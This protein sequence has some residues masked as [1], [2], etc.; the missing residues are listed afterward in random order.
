[1]RQWSI[2]V[3]SL[4][5]TFSTAGMRRQAIF[6]LL[7]LFAFAWGSDD[8]HV[9]D[10]FRPPAVPLIVFDPYMNI[11]ST[12]NNLY[13]SWPSLWDGAT[14]GLS[15]LIRV[16]GK[17]YRFMGLGDVANTVSQ[18]SVKVLPTTTVYKFK[19]GGVA[20]TVRFITP[21]IPQDIQLLSQPVSYI[22]YD[23][24]SADGKT[25]KV[26]LYYD[27]S[28][29]VCSNWSDRKITW[30]RGTVGNVTFLKMGV[31]QQKEFD[32]IGDRVGINWGYAYVAVGD[33]NAKTSINSD[34]TSRKTFA[35]TGS[36]PTTDDTRK[37]RAVQDEWPVMSVSWS[38]TLSPQESVSK[39]VIFAYDDVHSINW[40]GTPFPPLWKQY[41]PSTTGLLETA[42]NQYT[43]IL[44]TT[45]RLDAAV[46][47]QVFKAAGLHYSTIASLA[48]RQTF[49]AHK[50]VYNTKLKVP[51]YFLKEIS[52]NGDFSTV[53]VLFP[54]IPLLLWANPNLAEMILLPHL[55]YAAG[56]APIKYDLPW[57]PHQLGV[58]PVADATPDSQEQMPV[59]ET[60]NLLLIAEYLA[61]SGVQYTKRMYPRYKS[62]FDKWAKYLTPHKLTGVV[63]ENV[64]RMG[65]DLPNMPTTATSANDCRQKCQNKDG[66][67]SW[68]F[69][70]CSKNR[71]WLK[72]TEGQA[73]PADCRSSGLKKP[74]SS[75]LGGI[76]PDPDNQLCTDDFLGPMPHNVNLAAKGILAVD[77]YAGFLKNLGRANESQYFTSTAK[78][79]SDWWMKNGK[80]GDHYRIQFDTPNSF[81]LQYNLIFQKF[82]HLST[83][84]E[85]VL[86]N[87]VNYYLNHQWNKYGAPLNSRAAKDGNVFTKLDWLS[88]SACLTN[89][90]K[91]SDKFWR[92][93]FQLANDTPDRVPLT[94]WYNTKNGKQVGFQARPVV[95]GFYAYM[96]LQ[97]QGRLVFDL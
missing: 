46:L 91:K 35:N 95:G 5:A 19:A 38:F 93:I 88:W 32:P 71:C 73:T 94:D 31:D 75:Y 49:G 36:V 67:Q 40:F 61:Q 41:Y 28:G 42:Q 69:D 20:L 16:D 2:I 80:D 17:T 90:A 82:L 15:G 89:D 54:T 60:G 30:S 58:W 76:L 70:S 55:S 92:A 84:P 43:S 14:K 3:T 21:S 48:W 96:L 79:Y 44:N 39:H 24:H 53:D 33:S 18:E 56:E 52:S 65:N 72:S 59:E 22:V 1:M 13:D 68:A 12:S 8:Q 10:G 77:G 7:Y 78:D 97:N 50:L 26:D 6:F 66:C 9:A 57:A 25:H 11:W 29:E 45:Q 74:V 4:A 81:S 51:W 87:E 62:I 63:D 27:Q 64:D 37:P 83:F 86:E 34:S 85:S 23:V 47:N